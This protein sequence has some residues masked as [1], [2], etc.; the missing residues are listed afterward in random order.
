METFAPLALEHEALW[1]GIARALR[2]AIVLG[3]I[4]P[5]ARLEEPDLAR[6]FGVSRLP[7]REAIS[8]L[9]REGLVLVEPRRGASV[10]SIGVDDI[11][12]LFDFRLQLETYA[13]RRAVDRISPEDIMRLETLVEE[14]AEAVRSGQLNRFAAPDLKFHGYIVTL[15]G[16]RWLTSA[17]EPISGLIETMLSI[18]DTTYRDMP[19]SIQGHRTLVRSLADKDIGSAELGLQYHLANAERVLS[20]VM[21]VSSAKT[22]QTA[23]AESRR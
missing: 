1:E 13:V 22:S 14:M 7:V 2:Q 8:Q 17:W 4:G 19:A 20:Q 5:G 15:A 16:N 11:H 21:M 18:T 9:S 3:E 23:G 6:R 10:V 12:D